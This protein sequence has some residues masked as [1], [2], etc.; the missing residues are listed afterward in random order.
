MLMMLSALLLLTLVSP[1]STV[2]AVRAAEATR[3]QA[4]LAADFAAVDRLLADELTYTHS[5]AK[6]DNKAAYLEPFLSG[7]T[8]YQPW[9]RPR[10]RSA[11]TARPRS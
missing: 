1:Q 4:M 11:F 3:I 6:Q 2:D 10:C 8:R 5:N 7:R 9:S